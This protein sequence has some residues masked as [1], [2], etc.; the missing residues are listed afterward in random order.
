MVN[1]K[2]I[3]LDI[4]GTLLSDNNTITNENINVLKKAK[5]SGIKIALITAREY[6]STKYISNLIGC[7][8][9]IFSNGNH[10]FD[11]NFNKT[12]K[13]TYISKEAFK[14][15]YMFC[16]KNN[17]YIHV[18][19]EYEEVSDQLEYFCLKH[20][21][22]N[23]KYSDDLKSNCYV[24]GDLID[25]IRN[26][27]ISKIVIVS[28][29]KMDNYIKQLDA[30]LKKYNLF[31][32]ENNNDL[33]ESILNKT[34]NYIEIGACNSTKSTGLKYLINKLKINPGNVYVFG[35]GINDYEVLNEF[36]NS[37]CMVNGCKEVKN[38]SKYITT[39]D[40][41]NSGVAEMVKKIIRGDM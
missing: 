7:D 25:Y 13:I 12:I 17:L 16:K 37:I 35:D 34:I 1:T 40:N 24:V 30:I 29:N 33:Y 20:K 6:S 31:I 26:K 36:K 10:I 23:E 5:S 3:A 2:L 8:Y 9:G 22:L 11:L 28:E 32:T 39:K 41:N 38:I 14:D 18:N 27:D 4:G 19:L 15:I 21:L